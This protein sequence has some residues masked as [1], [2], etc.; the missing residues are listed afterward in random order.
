[1][2]K[3]DDVLIEWKTEVIAAVTYVV[4]YL[5]TRGRPRQTAGGKQAVYD[6]R[7]KRKRRNRSDGGLEWL[8][9]VLF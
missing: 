8:C 4:T 1:M 6:S 9:L 5:P 2:A 7:N 3:A